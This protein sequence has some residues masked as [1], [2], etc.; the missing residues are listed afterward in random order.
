MPLDIFKQ[1]NRKKL[2]RYAKGAAYT[3]LGLTIGV[4]AA[5]AVKKAKDRQKERLG[6][7][8]DIIW[9]N[10]EVFDNY[11]AW[12][13]DTERRRLG[14]KFAQQQRLLQSAEQQRLLDEE[15]LQRD[16]RVSDLRA[17][18]YQNFPGSEGL[19]M[20]IASTSKDPIPG[21]S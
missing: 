1:K 3:V 8:G 6:N 13:L 16:L 10:G 11:L 18:H 17:A 19:G 21:F 12:Q 15:M 9:D 4:G 2:R 7:H 14:Q 5:A 20:P